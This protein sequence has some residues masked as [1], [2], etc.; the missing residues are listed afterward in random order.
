MLKRQTTVMEPP[1]AK[2][3]GGFFAYQWHV[4]VFCNS[5][6]RHV[7]APINLERTTHAHAAL[8]SALCR[9]CSYMGSSLFSHSFL[10]SYRWL[11]PFASL[12]LDNN[13]HVQVFVAFLIM[14]NFSANVIEKQIDPT[15]K[16]FPTAFKSLEDMFNLIFLVELL[17]NMYGHWLKRFWCSSWNIFDFVVVVVGC[18]SLSWFNIELPGPLSLLRTL[19]AFRVF[20]LFKRVPS[21]NKIIVALAAAIPGTLN[22]FVVLFL[23]VSICKRPHFVLASPRRAF[24]CLPLC[25]CSLI[26]PLHSF[27]YAHMPRIAYATHPYPIRCASSLYPHTLSLS[28]SRV[29]RRHPRCG[30]LLQLRSLSLQGRCRHARGR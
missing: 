19:R 13:K 4:R 21:L 3:V 2:P 20:R 28:L 17:V 5:R 26:A 15:G 29:H 10:S 8:S 9:A 6:A 24:P 14:A 25:R 27:A 23:F 18:I 30:I 16:R 12:S 1:P 7:P 11:F 22:A